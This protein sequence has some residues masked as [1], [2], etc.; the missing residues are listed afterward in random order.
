MSYREI[1]DK[2]FN[3]VNF[4]GHYRNQPKNSNMSLKSR[5]IEDERVGLNNFQ[6]T[7]NSENVD[8]KDF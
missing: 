2:I 5:V 3:N 6:L 1:P 4:S 7:I 8:S